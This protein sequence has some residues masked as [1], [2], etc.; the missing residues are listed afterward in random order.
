MKGRANGESSALLALAMAVTS[1][2]CAA[3]DRPT[4]VPISLQG[5]FAV[6]TVNIDGNDVRLVF[7]SGDSVSVALS[8][9]VLDRIKATPSGETSKGMDPKGNLIEYHKYNLRRIQIGAAIF[10]DVIGELDAH[11]PS[12]QATQVGQEGFLG[13]AL[14]KGYKVVVDY[15]HQRMT[16]MPPD[17]ATDQPSS[18]K[19]SA[20]PFSTEWHGEPATEVE[21]DLGRLV[22]WWDTGSP[23]SLISKRFVQKARPS[24]S[25]DTVVSNQFTFGGTEYGPFEL[26]IADLSLPPG[27]DGFIGYNFFASHIVCLDFP[28]RRL[29]IQH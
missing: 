9:A 13:T 2:G 14:F 22:V 18:C 29:L 5:N 10:T 3:A 6:V 4:V 26:E 27:F 25:G 15:P 7:D 17:G 19:G 11:D 24:L 1:S 23:T 8:Q 28:G 12:Y 21:T 20:V 16:L